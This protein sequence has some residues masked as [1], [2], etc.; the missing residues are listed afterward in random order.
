MQ[1]AEFSAV[2]RMLDSFFP[3]PCPNSSEDMLPFNRSKI[4]TLSLK[5]STL[6]LTLLLGQHLLFGRHIF[7]KLRA[8]KHSDHTQFKHTDNNAGLT[9]S[10]SP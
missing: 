3:S 9:E 10:F 8:G 7:A 4:F 1:D 6:T 2:L 5:L